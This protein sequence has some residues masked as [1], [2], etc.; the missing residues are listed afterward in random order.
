MVQTF[1]GHLIK[2][3]H[4]LTHFTEHELEEFKKCADPVTGPEYFMNNYY[5]IEGRDG[6]MLYT[7]FA[8]QD[9][10]LDSYHNYRYSIGLLPR[11]TGKTTCAAGYLLWYAMFTPNRTTLIT[12]HKADH[13]KEVIH[14][15]QFAY[16]SCPDFI[17]CG[18]VS[19]PKM[20]MEFDNGSRILTEATTEKTGRGKTIHLL[21][22]DEM[23]FVRHSIQ[24][25]FWGSISATLTQSQGKCIITSTPSSD[26]DQFAYIWKKANETLDE[27]GNEQEVGSNGFK[28][29]QAHWQ[30][31]PDRD[32]KWADEERIRIGDIRFRIEHE[33]EFLSHEE[34]LIDPRKLRMMEGVAP[35][36]KMG[37]VRWYQKILRDRAYI[38]ALDPSIGTGGDNSAIQVFQLP[39]MIQVGEWM[40]NETRIDG[41]IRVL[42]EITRYLDDEMVSQGQKD[43]REIYYSVEN[44][45]VGEAALVEIGHVG[46][47]NITGEFISE[48]KSMGKVKQFRKG[49]TTTTKTKKLC[50]VK[51]KQ[52]I[53][54]NIM[55]IYSKP[56]ITELKQ[57]V[58]KG[59]S[60][61]AKLGSHDDLVAA[62]LIV[63]QVSMELIKWDPKLHNRL[64]E[65]ISDNE[66]IDPMPIMIF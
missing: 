48:S 38:V 18:A 8:F 16:E 64:R 62:T 37:Q 39:E 60:Y 41:Q 32:Q 63:I 21:Y 49:F 23:A 1:E 4:T 33:C 51:L 47:E 26:E 31:H 66:R 50:C 9:R 55:Q 11:Q 2:K 7:S 19:Y 43:R 58:A 34:T 59:M 61:E 46:E 20:S 53:E 65:T 25:E 36:V 10:L 27:F 52:Y 30:E 3:A 22:I 44:N 42:Q 14:R 28:A 57:Y 45:T 54:D 56:L 6:K 40:H 24:E 5:W 29:V 13:T 35:M 17:R 12:A 15:I